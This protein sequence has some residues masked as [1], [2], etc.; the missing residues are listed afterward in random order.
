[1]LHSGDR[2]TVTQGL[3]NAEIFVV[4]VVRYTM[5]KREE[6]KAPQMKQQVWCWELMEKQTDAQ[7]DHDLRE[8]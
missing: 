6:R 4:L 2:G 3:V 5:G 7:R 8:D 1:M